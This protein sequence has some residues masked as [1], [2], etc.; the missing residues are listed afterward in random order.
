MINK[1]DLPSNSACITDIVTTTILDLRHSP[2]TTHILL[3]LDP[4]SL[5]SRRSQENGWSGVAG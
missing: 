5:L 3:D 4:L 1:L 2:R